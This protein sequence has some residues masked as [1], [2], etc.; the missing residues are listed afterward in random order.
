LESISTIAVAHVVAAIA[1]FR[2]KKSKQNA[3]KEEHQAEGP[4]NEIAEPPSPDHSSGDSPCDGDDW[5][6][7]DWDAVVAASTAAAAAA[8][9]SSTVMITML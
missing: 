8:A 2:D 3:S 4:A 9:V 7:D 5:D 1:V 6:D